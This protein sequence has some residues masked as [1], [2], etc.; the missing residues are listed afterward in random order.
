MSSYLVEIFVC[1]CVFCLALLP[2]SIDLSF[3]HIISLCDSDYSE[4]ACEHE[5]HQDV[6]VQHEA[7]EGSLALVPIELIEA[8]GDIGF[9]DPHIGHQ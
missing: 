2:L 5:H 8:A 4:A 1:A 6:I 9:E 7:H 3:V